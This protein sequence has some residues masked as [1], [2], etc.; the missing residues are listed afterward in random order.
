MY[1]S[2]PWTARVSWCGWKRI[3]SCR[4]SDRTSPP[5]NQG[6]QQVRRHDTVVKVLWGQ[7]QVQLIHQES[8]LIFEFWFH[9]TAC[10]EAFVYYEYML[11]LYAN[12]TIHL[13]R[14]LVKLTEYIDSLRRQLN[15]QKVN[16]LLHTCAVLDRQWSWRHNRF[17]L[18]LSLLLCQQL[19][20][21]QVQ[22]P[23]ISCKDEGGHRPAL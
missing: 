4:R 10:G 8:C 21:S 22:L 15:N 6:F 3:H 16:G 14:I 9:H 1:P 20:P 13:Y 12:H 23:L 2:F 19:P 7:N 18:L 5:H 17:L 11:T